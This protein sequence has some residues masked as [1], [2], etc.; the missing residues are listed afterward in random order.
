MLWYNGGTDLCIGLN[1][2]DT[3]LVALVLVPLIT[4]RLFLMTR[5][6]TVVLVKVIYNPNLG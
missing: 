6:F 5:V 3:V 1:G 2:G 4:C